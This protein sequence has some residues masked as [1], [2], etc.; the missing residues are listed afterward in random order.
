M[1]NLK[2]L[3][4]KSG[5]VSLWSQ[6]RKGVPKQDI[7]SISHIPQIWQNWKHLYIRIHHLKWW[8]NKLQKTQAYKQ[9]KI[10][11]RVGKEAYKL[12]WRRQSNKWTN[13]MNRESHWDLQSS[14]IF[15]LP[16]SSPHCVIPFLLPLKFDNLLS[17]SIPFISL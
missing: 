11:F 7:K 6:S 10:G 5:R 17:W 14:N 3:W 1:W 9:Q 12:I 2:I 15:I 13:K 4:R 16:V 8:K